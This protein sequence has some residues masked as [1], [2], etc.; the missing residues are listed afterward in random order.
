V[1]NSVFTDQSLVIGSL[2][3]N[4]LR[5]ARRTGSLHAGKTSGSDVAARIA[6]LAAATPHVATVADIGCGRGTT[7]LRLSATVPAGRQRDRRRSLSGLT[8]HRPGPRPHRLGVCCVDAG[9]VGA[10]TYSQLI[11][12]LSWRI[13]LEIEQESGRERRKAL[14]T[15]GDVTID[16]STVIIKAMGGTIDSADGMKLLEQ[17]FSLKPGLE[18]P[19]V[20]R[21][22]P[23]HV[24]VVVDEPNMPAGG[25]PKQIAGDQRAGVTHNSQRRPHRRGGSRRPR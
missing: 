21:G 10:D 22:D 17:A 19:V 1:T 12:G 3:A 14:R 23:A 4:P 25:Q 13:P 15:W 8:V 2:Y 20:E 5:L 16:S 11:G 18:A 24:E 7:T 6:A 9:S